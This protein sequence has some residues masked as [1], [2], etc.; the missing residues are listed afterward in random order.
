LI[1][2][3]FHRGCNIIRQEAE[4]STSR[5]QVACIADIYDSRTRNG[6]PEFEMMWSSNGMIRKVKTTCSVGSDSSNK[7]H[8]SIEKGEKRIGNLNATNPQTDLSDMKDDAS[9]ANG[10]NDPLRGTATSKDLPLL[11]HQDMATSEGRAFLSTFPLVR[12]LCNALNRAGY[13]AHMGDEGDIWFDDEDGD[14]YFDAL[15][16]QPRAGEPSIYVA[17]CHLCKNPDH[18]HLGDIVRRAQVGQQ[19]LQEYRDQVK[20]QKSM[21]FI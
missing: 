14:M 3:D 6:K 8:G 13:R 11:V 7:R 10:N 15:E 16:E 1:D 20:K 21:L 18:H 4:E 12:I 2:Y 5:S 19:K 9:E 17:N